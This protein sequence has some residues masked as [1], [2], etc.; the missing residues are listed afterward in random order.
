MGFTY[1][2]NQAPKRTAGIEKGTNH[3]KIF[4]LIDFLNTAILDAELVNVPIVKANG[5]T[6]EGKSKFS[7][8]MSIKLAPPPQIALIQNATT[9]APNNSTIF[10]IILFQLGERGFVI[11]ANNLYQH[12]FNTI[13]NDVNA[14]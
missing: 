4:Q 9:V 14:A 8:G 2:I 10:K 6:D 12:E 5:T 1:F 7:I 11:P 13:N 3:K